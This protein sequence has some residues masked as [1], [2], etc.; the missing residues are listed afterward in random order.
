MRLDDL[1]AGADLAPRQERQETDP[2]MDLPDFDDMPINMEDINQS[3]KKLDEII[4]QPIDEAGITAESYEIAGSQPNTVD[5]ATAPD[6]AVG[7]DSPDSL[8]K[9]IDREV[10]RPLYGEQPPVIEEPRP[11]ESPPYDTSL[12]EQ[13]QIISSGS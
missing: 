8:Q 5:E 1:L 12:D 2:T 7:V 3:Q 10:V 9:E 6:P 11:K 4:N 13:I